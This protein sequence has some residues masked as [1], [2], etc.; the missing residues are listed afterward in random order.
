V[1]QRQAGRHPPPL[2]D[3]AKSIRAFVNEARRDRP[4]LRDPIAR[5][6]AAMRMAQA[7]LER[8]RDEASR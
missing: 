4:Q 8:L 2:A 6:E 1:P 5:A 7:R 3:F